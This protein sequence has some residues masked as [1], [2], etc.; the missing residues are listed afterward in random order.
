MS[1]AVQLLEL[2]VRITPSY[3]LGW[4]KLATLHDHADNFDVSL[5]V[6]RVAFRE[7][8]H[9]R[10]DPSLRLS[11]GVEEARMTARREGRRVVV[12]YCDEYGQTWWPRWGPTSMDRGGAGGSEEAVIFITAEMVR[13]GYHVEVYGEPMEEEWGRHEPTGVWWLPLETYDQRSFLGNM[14][15]GNKGSSSI[16]GSGSNDGGNDGERVF[17]P[18]DIFVAWRY[19]ISMFAG[20]DA[21]TQRYLWLQDISSRFVR[22]YTPKFVSSLHGLFVLSS[23]HARE[24]L[25][26]HAEQITTIT[27]NGLDADYYVDG[28]NHNH[29]FMYA[30]APNRGL[31]QV[32]LAWPSIRAA[33]RV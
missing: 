19:H 31:R 8:F 15:G 28:P 18:P 25:P 24:G 6:Y 11:L 5:G 14:G 26:N 16:S 23:F 33:V 17:T 29:K 4:M 7:Q 3:D 10:F 9:R 32:L 12:V 20:D 30:S 1:L 2:S 13:L 21:R 22:Q 27:P